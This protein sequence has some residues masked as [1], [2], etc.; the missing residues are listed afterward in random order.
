MAARISVGCIVV[1]TPDKNPVTGQDVPHARSGHCCVADSSS[2]YSLGGIYYDPLEILNLEDEEN[3]NPV[4]QEVWCY[5]TSLNIWSKVKMEGTV[6]PL[7]ASMSSIL[8]GHVVFTFGG[9]GFPFGARSDNRV[10]TFNLK[11]QCWATLPLKGDLPHAKYGQAMAL[12][13]NQYLYVFGGCRK[14][15]EGGLFVFDSDLHRMKLETYCWEKVKDPVME[16]QKNRKRKEKKK[17]NNDDENDAVKKE[18]E[19]EEEEEDN[20]MYPLRNGSYRHQVAND[21]DRLYVLGGGTL[22]REVFPFDKIHAFNYATSRWEILS[23]H[24]DG[25]CAEGFPSPRKYHTCVQKGDGTTDFGLTL[26]AAKFKSIMF[27]N[28]RAASRFKLAT[29]FPQKVTATADSGD[30]GVGSYRIVAS[31]QQVHC[32]YWITTFFLFRS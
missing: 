10:H 15:P 32:G 24:R 4:F 29:F 28:N 27:A 22:W 5:N 23:S 20:E 11:T 31:Q 19:V 6:P 9:S 30:L 18:N 21:E 16:A 14:L 13:H 25:H 7:T 12:V 17:S 3:F 8:S 26:V 1:L 2:V